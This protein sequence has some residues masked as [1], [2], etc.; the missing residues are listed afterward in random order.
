[1]EGGKIPDDLDTLFHGKGEV[2]GGVVC[3]QK[4]TKNNN[5]NRR[6]GAQAYRPAAAD[7]QIPVRRGS[8]GFNAGRQ[9]FSGYLATTPA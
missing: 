2:A 8:P 1:V 3:G 5:R 7:L 6:P 9:V 4:I